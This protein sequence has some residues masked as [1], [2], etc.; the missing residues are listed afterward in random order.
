MKKQ[1]QLII[2]FISIL[3]MINYLTACSSNS[4]RDYST[5]ESSITVV[6]TE[7]TKK[8]EPI[9]TVSPSPIVKPTEEP[10]PSPEPIM[11]EG[12]DMESTL[13]GEEWV[14]SLETVI[15]EPK[16]V[17]FNDKTN[18]KVIVENG[19]EVEFATDDILAIHSPGDTIYVM[20]DYDN[21]INRGGTLVHIQW[22]PFPWILEQGSTVTKNIIEFN[23]KEMILE[24][25]L[26]FVE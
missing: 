16:L 1:S 20:S 17:I 15:T 26:I 2:A 13:P 3:V 7:T 11:Y 14:R 21:F 12:V 4:E 6:S 9:L 24:A 25:T 22:D 19:Q 10:S 5:S 18:K 23:G 8:Y